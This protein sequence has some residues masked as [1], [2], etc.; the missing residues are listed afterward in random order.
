MMAR[1]LGQVLA[2]WIV[3][4]AV[5]GAVWSVTSPCTGRVLW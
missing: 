1:V 2:R 5:T 4:A 3:G